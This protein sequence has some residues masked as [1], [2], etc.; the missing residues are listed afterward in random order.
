MEEKVIFLPTAKKIDGKDEKE[1]LELSEVSQEKNSL[2]EIEKT[3]LKRQVGLIGG[4]CLL[5]GTMIGSGIFAS[6]SSVATFA[7]DP[8]PVLLVWA[9]SGVLAMLAALCWCELGTMFPNASGGEYSYF[10]AAFGPLPAFLFSFTTVFILKPSSLVLIT[11]T[12]GNYIITAIGYEPE[13]TAYNKLIAA[14]LLGI[15]VFVNCASVRWA[16]S[17][18]VIFTATK[19]LAIVMLIITGF[20]RLGQGHN[21]SLKDAFNGTSK[22]I[23]DIGY[24]FYGGLWAYD[25]WNNLNYVT[26][27]L[28]NPIRDLPLAIMIGIPLVTACYVMVNITYLTVLTSIQI[29]SSKA[30]AVTLANQLYGVM[31]WVIPVFVACSTF[32]AANGSAFTSGRLVYV[33]AR[34]GHMPKLLAMVHTKRHTPLP[35]LIF[36][37]IIAWIMLIPESSNFSTLVNYFN[38]AAWT[39]YGGTVAALLWLRIR[40]PDLERP[41]KVFIGIPIVVLLCSLYLVIAP[42]YDYP[43]QSLYCLLFILFGIPVYFLFVKYQVFPKAITTGF[44][45]FVDKITYK[46]QMLCDLSMP[47][48]FDED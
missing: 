4:V 35:A 47:D 42:F 40:Q 12:C 1:T 37:C 2:A 41:Y 10:H 30:V 19:L 38:F 3:G 18:Q 11:I 27:E 29:A 44:G 9:G 36:T 5:V 6:P 7:G 33:S 23:S 24:A 31:A 48:D 34:E 32:G 16:T 17:V 25:G 20:V 14:V 28:K 22:S 46:I 13:R 26:E 43:L 39:F 8:G 45:S 21:D 15:I